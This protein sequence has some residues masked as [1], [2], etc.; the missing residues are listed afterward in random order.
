MSEPAQLHTLSLLI[1]INH[2]SNATAYLSNVFWP[3]LT[4]FSSMI[5]QLITKQNPSQALR[6]HDP[7]N[8]LRV[9][10]QLSKTPDWDSVEHV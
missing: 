5:K 3:E 9:L 2:R 7:N 8:E 6:F 4:F 10:Q 1:P